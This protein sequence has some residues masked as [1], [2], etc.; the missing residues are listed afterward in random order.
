MIFRD[1]DMPPFSHHSAG[2]GQLGCFHSVAI[3]DNAARNI[4]VQGLGWLYRNDSVVSVIV[5]EE[6]IGSDMA[7]V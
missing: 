5:T 6:A 7:R 3:M 4:R 2:D 1:T